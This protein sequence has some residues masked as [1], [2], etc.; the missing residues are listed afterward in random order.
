M[1]PPWQKIARV[2]VYLFTYHAYRSWMP[3]HPRGFAKEGEGYQQPNPE[4]ARAYEDAAKFPA[5]E[6]DAPTERFLIET[7]C[8]VCERRGWRFHGAATEPSHLH[9]LVSWRDPSLQWSFVRGKIKNILSL[10]LSKRSATV[11]R[12]WFVEGASRKRVRDWDH[13][14]YLMVTYLP[15]RHGGWRWTERAGWIEPRKNHGRRKR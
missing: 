10:E 4:L 6:F 5:V 13:F 2:P 1:P 11:G 3:D 15:K 8:E 9:A 12:R 14:D 7:A